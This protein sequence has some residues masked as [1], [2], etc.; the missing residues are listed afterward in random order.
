MSNQEQHKLR[1]DFEKLRQAVSE[2]AHFIRE[3]PE[4]ALVEKAWGPR[5]VVAHL[6][7]W[8][9]SYVIQAEAILAQKQPEPP[10]GHFGELNAKMIEASRDVPVINLLR[11]QQAACER[12]G[13]L[14]QILDSSTVMLELKKGSVPHSLTWF[15]VGEAGHIRH[16]HQRLIRQVRRDYLSEI[17]KLRK[18]VEKFCHLIRVLPEV[19]LIKQAWGPK[20]VLAHLVFWHERYIAQIEAILAEKAFTGSQGRRDDLNAQALEASHNVS[21][22]EL[23]G[24]FQVA[25][26]RL[27]EFG[28][29]LDPQNIIVEERTLDDLISKVKSHIRNHHLELVRKMK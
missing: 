23:L 26:E 6:V 12:L 29:T 15:I 22:A 10:Q 17:E 9:E 3:L 18:T 7:F 16:H 25:D 24:R 13:N 20:E 4:V 21:V 5:E 14:A 8:I 28:Q 19:A 11:R 2:F 1:S 27:R